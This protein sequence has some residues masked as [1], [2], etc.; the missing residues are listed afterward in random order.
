MASNN[1]TQVS[2]KTSDEIAEE[3]YLKSYEELRKRGRNE[4]ESYASAIKLR[5][6]V[7]LVIESRIALRA[8]YF[9]LQS[10]SFDPD[11]MD[12]NNMDDN[13]EN[14]DGSTVSSSDEQDDA[15]DECH[16]IPVCD[17]VV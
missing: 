12:D 14:S 11:E 17:T 10:S 1:P 2:R 13:D 15:R 7:L 9:Y 6:S 3:V 5:T 4:E 8:I 16:V